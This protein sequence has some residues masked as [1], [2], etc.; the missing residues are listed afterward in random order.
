MTRAADSITC[1]RSPTATPADAG[2][3]SSLHGTRVAMKAEATGKARKL[4]AFPPR[5]V[6]VRLEA[7]TY[8]DRGALLRTGRRSA[9]SVN[10]HMPDTVRAGFWP[11]RD[12]H[13]PI[14]G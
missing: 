5:C 9:R 10:V 13:S 1:R 7:V 14:A 8:T 4:R 3:R 6:S 12:T 2:A 11:L